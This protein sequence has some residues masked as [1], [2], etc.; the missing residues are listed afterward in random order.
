PE[1]LPRCAEDPPP[2][3]PLAGAPRDPARGARRP[4]HRRGRGAPGLAG[5]AAAPRPRRALDGGTPR[6][7]AALRRD[8]FLRGDG[9]ALRRAPRHAADA[10]DPGDS[11]APALARVPGHHRIL[12]PDA[13][14]DALPRAS[15]WC[16]EPSTR[17]AAHPEHHLSSDL[18]NL[19]VASLASCAAAA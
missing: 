2:A 11:G 10:G 14:A 6:R 1:P 8:A 16:G 5:P 4:V 18:R 15:P 13:G 19:R 7:R 9:P 12:S 17:G 3:T